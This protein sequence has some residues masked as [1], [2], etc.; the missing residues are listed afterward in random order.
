MNQK[1]LREAMVYLKNNGKQ[2]TRKH[3]SQYGYTV[4]EHPNVSSA[5]IMVK[6]GKIVGQTN[7][8][9]ILANNSRTQAKLET[10]DFLEFTL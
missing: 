6:D 4:Y 10:A 7:K 2:I 9:K 5:V 1:L 3:I 8:T